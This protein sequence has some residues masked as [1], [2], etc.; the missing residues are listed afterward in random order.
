[1]KKQFLFA[2]MFSLISLFASAQT[3]TNGEVDMI[4]VP[5]WV[6]NKGYWVVES[7]LK[8]PKTSI[9]YFYT[10]ENLLV[11]KEKVEGIVLNLKKTKIKMCLK[12]VLEQSVYAYAQRRA[13]SENEAWVASSFKKK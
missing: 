10:N 8:N 9:V 13:V 11:Y 1:M 7:T 2:V 12:K 5:K 6:S 4:P 3:E